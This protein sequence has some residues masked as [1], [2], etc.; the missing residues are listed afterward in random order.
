MRSCAYIILGLFGGLLAF[1]PAAQA[2]HIEAGELTTLNT[3]TTPQFNVVTFQQPFDVIPVVTALLTSQDAAPA[4][5]RIRNVSTTGFEI[6]AAEPPS[7]D[8]GHGAEIVH[9]IAVEPGITTLPDGTV[10]AAGLHQTT[11]TL[12]GSGTT[13]PDVYDTV[14]FGVT[15]SAPPSIIA[16]IQ[17]LNNEENNIPATF[18]Q[19][20]LSA[21]IN[22]ATASTVDLSLERSE[23][24]NFGSVTTN[25]TI[26]WIAFPSGSSGSL[27]DINGQSINWEARLTPLNIRGISNGCFTNTFSAAPFANA[28]VVATKATRRGG[29]GGWLRR[30]SLSN[31]AI[32]LQVDEDTTLNVER[33]HID[34]SASILAFSGSFH[35]VLEG[36]L[37]GNKQVE[38]VT[39]SEYS[40]PGN[41]VL[42]RLSAE[43]IGNGAVDNGSV[44][45]TDSLPPEI[46]LSVAD[47]DGAGSGPVRFIDGAPP[48]GLN[49]NFGGLAAPGDDIAFSNDNA[50][51]FT[52]TPVPN[53]SGTDSNITHIRISPS[54]TFIAQSGS[55][56]P[57]FAVEF[58]AVI[59]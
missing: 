27:R 3:N 29:D 52:Y 50:A 13:G 28:R 59:Q 46:A 56:P 47:I 16:N 38:M 54:G 9:Y 43:N 8:G 49:L 25:E 45:L 53:A 44:I 5:L 58:E 36:R 2:R 48:S 20:F 26:G 6:I 32:G 11:S 22:N 24:T 30:C 12:T 35:A 41:R 7:L 33:N 37:Q 40:L 31:T 21:G 4:D 57:S 10:I 19:P 14:P 18:S 1:S 42:Y 15:L 39:N 17:T 23:T 55:S 34:E 51:S